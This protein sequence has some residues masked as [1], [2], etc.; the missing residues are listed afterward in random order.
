MGI[1]FIPSRLVHSYLDLHH[2]VSFVWNIQTPG[3]EFLERPEVWSCCT[4]QSF[5][6][7][8]PILDSRELIQ[9]QTWRGKRVQGSPVQK[10]P[11]KD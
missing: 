1:A 2:N 11:L 4:C 8:F 9:S 3:I 10:S 6:T 7:R 5:F